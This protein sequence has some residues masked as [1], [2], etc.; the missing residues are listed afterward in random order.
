MC[1]RKQAFAPLPGG[2]R[3]G[4]SNGRQDHRRHRDR[5]ERQ[6]DVFSRRAGINGV[7]GLSRLDAAEVAEL[8]PS[9]RCSG[10]LLHS[11][12]TG[13]LDTH[14]YMRRCKVTRRNGA[15]LA[16]KS[17]VLAGRSDRPRTC[18]LTVGGDDPDAE[19]L[20]TG[21]QCRRPGRSGPRPGLPRIAEGIGAA[22]LP[23][24]RQLFPVERAHAICNAWFIRFP[25]V[26]DWASIT[27]WTLAARVGSGPMWSG[28]RPEV[29]TSTH[30]PRRAFYEAIRRYWPVLPEG[31]LRP[32]FPGCAEIARR[33]GTRRGFSSSRVRT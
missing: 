15:V 33:R 20:P 27:L 13:I 24:Q 4:P 11:A 8:E 14:G 7:E 31:R 32:D 2:A 25:R 18:M 29:T 21:G 10:P 9:V 22:A 17:P 23:V 6:L 1:R 3:C 30:P 28:S 12:T 16:L 5:R 19:S 26:P